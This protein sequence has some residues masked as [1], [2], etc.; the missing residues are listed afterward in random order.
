M[1]TAG[2][3]NREGPQ[4]TRPRRC[5]LAPARSVKG[6][7]ARFPTPRLSA[8]FGFRKETIAGI[9]RHGRG[10][11]TPDLRA[12]ALE[13]V[14]STLSGRL[15]SGDRDSKKPEADVHGFRTKPRRLVSGKRTLPGSISDGSIARTLSS[16]QSRGGCLFLSDVEL[17][18]AGGTTASA[19]PP[20]PARA[21]TTARPFSRRPTL[22]QQLH[23]PT[24]RDA[25][26]KHKG[27]DA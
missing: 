19:A 21:R 17:G 1:G 10:A 5:S 3:A 23:C 25:V 22:P 4:S 26:R 20:S 12:R 24:T 2:Q 14:G 16:N 7:E 15:L 9:R 18:Q 6:H 11:P 13:R 27:F 8:G